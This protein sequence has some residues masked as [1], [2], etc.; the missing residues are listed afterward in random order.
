MHLRHNV[1]GTSLKPL[2]PLITVRLS[3]D[4]FHKR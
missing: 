4:W 3:M 1:Q 2:K